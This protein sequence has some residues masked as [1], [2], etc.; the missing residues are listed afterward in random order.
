[1]TTTFLSQLPVTQFIPLVNGALKN[2]QSVLALARSPLA[3]SALVHPLLVLD[4]VSPTADERGHALRLLLQWAVARLAPGP[5]TSPFGT[6][7]SYDDPTWREPHWWRYNILRHRYLEP[8][9]PDEFIDGGRYTETLIALTG[10]TST[11]TFFDERNRAIREVA[12]RLQEQLTTGQANEE[13]Q[14]LALDE[15]LRPLAAKPSAQ[16]LLALA[17]TF[18][19]VFPRSLLL[20][21]AAAE[22]VPEPATAL[23]ALTADR[24]LLMGDGGVN[25]WLSPILQRAVYFRQRVAD[26]RHRHRTVSTYYQREEESLKAAEHAMRAQDWEAAATGLLATAHTLINDLQTDELLALLTQFPADGMSPACWCDLQLLAADLYRRQGQQE[27]ALAAC[28]Q[29]LRVAT[30]TQQQGQLYWRMGKLYE[31]RNALQALDYYERALVCFPPTAPTAVEVRKDRAWLYI[32]RRE[33]Q[34]A[35]ADLQHALLLVAELADDANAVDRETAKSDTNELHANL[36]DAHAHLYLEQGQASA[37]IAYA[38]QSLHLRERTGDLLQVAKSFN[39]LGNFYSRMGEVEAAIAAHDEAIQLYRRLNNQELEAE[40]WLNQGVVY[41]VA[42]RQAE[43]IRQYHKSLGL[44]QQLG[45]LLTEIT[46]HAN[47]V[48]AYAELAQT[49]DAV[50]HWHFAQALCQQAD[51]VTELQELAEL[52][53]RFAL[54]VHEEYSTPAPMATGAHSLPP[55]ALLTP[56]AQAVL[57]LAEAEEQVTP[58]LVMA[59]RHVSKATATRRLQ[60]LTKAGF[61]RKQ[62]KG[63]GT[64]YVAAT[65]ASEPIAW[66]T[67]PRLPATQHVDVNETMMTLQRLLTPCVAWMTEEY[68]VAGVLLLRPLPIY[69]GTWQLGVEFQ[70]P[71]TLNAFFALEQQLGKVCGVAVDLLPVDS[72]SLAQR[73]QGIRL[74]LF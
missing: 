8:L 39:N 63:R 22:Q 26:L 58:K 24:Y 68:R 2:Y 9:H 35:E 19:D 62:G 27:S 66:S 6:D 12:Q 49:E 52:R 30:D 57:A 7:R 71:P 65:A 55:R 70:A 64:R 11:D 29:A 43:A 13:L 14:Q 46:A 45:F 73:E 5:V 23:D 28:R 20:R 44:S 67:T 4:D 32:L 31:K 15:L 60:E 69:G 25:L 3:D 36:L 59:R 37:A 54:P 61:L 47:L 41:H 74:A 53:T 48:E 50:R 10:I 21:M 72:L 38:R 18:D 51:F 33:W 16:A 1:M 42:A 56:D 17:A 40:T 34:A